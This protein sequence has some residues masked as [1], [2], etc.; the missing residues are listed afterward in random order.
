LRVRQ[1][2]L[3]PDEWLVQGT[4]HNGAHFPLCIFTH[5]ESHRSEAA[6]LKRDAR[7]QARKKTGW[8]GAGARYSDLPPTFRSG[9]VTL[10]RYSCSQASGSQDVPQSRQQPFIL[11]PSLALLSIRR[12]GGN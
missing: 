7:Q 4:P 6:W 5:N 11:H 10:T 12:P 2:V 3:D 1:K 9:S 8:R